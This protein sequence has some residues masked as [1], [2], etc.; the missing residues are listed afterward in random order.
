[1]KRCE[2]CGAKS[3]DIDETQM[4]ERCRDERIYEPPETVHFAGNKK[5]L[6]TEDGDGWSHNSNRAREG[7]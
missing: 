2:S 3:D 5:P 1:M 4:C 7:D 6:T